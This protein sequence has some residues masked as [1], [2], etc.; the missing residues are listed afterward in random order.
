MT[1]THAARPAAVDSST[2]QADRSGSTFGG[3]TQEARFAQLTLFALINISHSNHCSF[4]FVFPG[5]SGDCFKASAPLFDHPEKPQSRDSGTC[6]PRGSIAEEENVSWALYSIDYISN[7][8]KSRRTDRL[9]F[10]WRNYSANA[11][12]MS[13]QIALNLNK[14][15][16]IREFLL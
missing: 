15:I 2:D 5:W 6:V 12:Q 8:I 1:R 14:E 13:C 11:L 9:G 16:C 10:R 4:E 7:C 3:Q